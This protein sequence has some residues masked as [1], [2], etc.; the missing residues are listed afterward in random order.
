M[1]T[2][3]NVEIEKLKNIILVKTKELEEMSTACRI[4]RNDLVHAIDE[5]N[6]NRE[7]I[8]DLSRKLFIKNTH[9]SHT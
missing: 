4:A 1:R 9:F 6:H 5:I 7:I 2:L 3:Q 8:E